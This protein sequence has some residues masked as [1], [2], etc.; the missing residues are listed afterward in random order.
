[1][2]ELNTSTNNVPQHSRTRDICRPAEFDG[3]NFIDACL[4]IATNSATKVRRDTNTWN[5]EDQ[6]IGLKPEQT[7]PPALLIKRTGAE[8]DCNGVWRRSCGRAESN[9]A[10]QW[11]D[12][13]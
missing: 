11:Q 7:C 2:V 1:M 13:L 8:G 12:R 3:I 5:C 10:E 4:Y 6:R 9:R